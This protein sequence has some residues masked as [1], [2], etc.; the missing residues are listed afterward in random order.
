MHVSRCHHRGQGHKVG[1]EFADGAMFKVSLG[2]AK[3]WHVLRITRCRGDEDQKTRTT[4]KVLR[5]GR[6][7]N[8]YIVEATFASL[9]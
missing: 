8:D 7:W 5:M 4:H 1:Y 3:G 6:S 9:S 2:S